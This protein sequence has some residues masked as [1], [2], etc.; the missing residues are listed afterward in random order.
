MQVLK[1]L[2]ADS[3]RDVRHFALACP[4]STDIEEVCNCKIV[5]IKMH[6]CHFAD[7]GTLLMH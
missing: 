7:Q 1:R 4:S 3:D 2:Q 6:S 5:N